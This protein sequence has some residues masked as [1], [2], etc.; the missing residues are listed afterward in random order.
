MKLEKGKKY[1]WVLDFFIAEFEVV[2]ILTIENFTAYQ[3]QSEE[4]FLSKLINGEDVKSNIEK[5]VINLT[6]EDA[7]KNMVKVYEKRIEDAECQIESYKR[8]IERLKGN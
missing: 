6:I 3:I 4:E 5:G 2:R 7:K 8:S 1:Y